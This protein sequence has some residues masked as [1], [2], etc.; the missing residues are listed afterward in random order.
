[1]ENFNLLDAILEGDEI[2]IVLDERLVRFSYDEGGGESAR[3]VR[4]S[5]F[6]PGK[7]PSCIDLIITDQPNLIL[8]SG[9]R[10]SLDPKFHHQIVYC[11]INFRIPP[12]PPIERKM[13]HYGKANKAAILRSV[14]NFPWIQHLSLNPDPNW[15]VKTFTEIRLNIMSNFIPNETRKCVPRDPTW[16][17]KH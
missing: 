15:Q 14:A 10:P 4:C 7:N 3:S 9:T 11:K 6:S 13:W 8:D 17:E 1:M 12:P 16:I 5:D 2:P